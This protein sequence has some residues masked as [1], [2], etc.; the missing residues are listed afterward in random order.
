MNPLLN[1]FSDV[2]EGM[3]KIEAQE[4]PS[5]VMPAEAQGNPRGFK[6]LDYAVLGVYQAPLEALGW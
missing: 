6:P 2:L 5:R 1:R 3:F 4:G